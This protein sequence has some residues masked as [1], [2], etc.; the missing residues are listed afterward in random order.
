MTADGSVH[1]K[2]G[3]RRLFLPLLEQD[4][5]YFFVL[6]ALAGTVNPPAGAGGA[7]SFLGFLVSLFPRN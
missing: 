2:V 7:F 1:E 3:L 5:T 6:S 4:A